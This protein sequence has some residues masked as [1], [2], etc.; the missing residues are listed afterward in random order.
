MNVALEVAQEHGAH[1]HALD[2]T[3]M[4]RDQHHI[5][6]RDGVFDQDE[7]AG[8]D[9][10]DQGLSTEADGQADHPGAG[11]QRRDVH[12]DF[13]QDDQG[14]QHHEHDAHGIL[15]QRQQCPQPLPATLGSPPLDRRLHVGGKD[16]PE[17]ERDDRDEA[18][19]KDGREQGPAIAAAQPAEGSKPP[20]LQNQQCGEDRQ[21][22]VEDAVKGGNVAVGA[23]LEEWIPST[24]ITMEAEDPF[25][26][27]RN[28]P[29]DHP[30]TG[31]DKNRQESAAQ[32]EMKAAFHIEGPDD[33]APDHIGNGQHVPYLRKTDPQVA[34]RGGSPPLADDQMLYG[35]TLLEDEDDHHARENQCQQRH[36]HVIGARGQ[37]E[38][39]ARQ[40]QKIAVDADEG[41]A[42]Q[43]DLQI[44]RRY[45]LDRQ[46]PHPRLVRHQNH[47]THGGNDAREQEGIDECQSDEP[48]YRAR[49]HQRKEP[50]GHH[51]EGEDRQNLQQCAQQ[52]VE[53]AEEPAI[54]APFAQSASRSRQQ[55]LDEKLGDQSDD[56]DK[57]HLAH[58]FRHAR[59][60]RR[61]PKAL[62]AAKGGQGELA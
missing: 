60:H 48:G 43:P 14:N 34:E 52:Q 38:H 58:H 53:R 56:D 20:D 29:P 44:E 6:N 26:K 41:E 39:L 21:A 1:R 19:Q 33:K 22:D 8:N 32:E 35:L 12:A 4:S 7:N 47:P 16:L 24:Q 3:G 11:Q 2:H 55:P 18:D 61:I 25:D 46:Q 23:L 37:P 42:P 62:D 57:G 45:I 50:I 5:S 31:K 36:E 15:R 30:R 17:Q 49:L 28:H 51:R 9:I 59:A 40:Q 10:L 27:Q 13:R 54:S